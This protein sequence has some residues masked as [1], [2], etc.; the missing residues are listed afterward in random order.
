MKKLIV[1]FL[2]FGKIGDEFVICVICLLKFI[3]NYCVVVVL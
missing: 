3:I 1:E 2:F